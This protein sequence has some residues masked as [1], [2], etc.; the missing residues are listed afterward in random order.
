MGRLGHFKELYHIY[1][2]AEDHEFN[3]FRRKTDTWGFNRNF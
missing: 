3:N 1:Q 2:A